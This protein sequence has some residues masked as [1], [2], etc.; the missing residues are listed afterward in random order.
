M[1]SKINSIAST[2]STDDQTCV[3]PTNQEL[4]TID[5]WLTQQLSFL[6]LS[7]CRNSVGSSDKTPDML[8]HHLSLGRGRTSCTPGAA[9]GRA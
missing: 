7:F 3:N 2:F 9:H 8:S 5:F 6:K 1:N 4:W